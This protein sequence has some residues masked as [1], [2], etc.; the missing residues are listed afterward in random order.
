[1]ADG[2]FGCILKFFHHAEEGEEEGVGVIVRSWGFEVRRSCLHHLCACRQVTL[3]VWA[4][5]SWSVD[6]DF[7]ITRK[8]Y[9]R[10]LL[11]EF[12]E[13]IHVKHLAKLL[14]IARCSQNVSYCCS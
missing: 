14:E 2:D 12:H 6:Q 4:S 11:K 7:T 13:M 8:T 3:T 1:M 10:E 5:A 9:F